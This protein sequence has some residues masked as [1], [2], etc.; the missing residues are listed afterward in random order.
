MKALFCGNARLLVL[1]ELA[2]KEGD[3]HGKEDEEETRCVHDLCLRVFRHILQREMRMIS[4]KW[5]VLAR[6]L[7]IMI[8]VCSHPGLVGPDHLFK[9]AH[10]GS[11]HGQGKD[12]GAKILIGGKRFCKKLF[13]TKYL[14]TR[15]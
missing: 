7:Q 13:C 3:P 8:N 4:D 1:G 12:G 15:M 5:L 2:E 11:C 6:V 14:L 10:T 9:V